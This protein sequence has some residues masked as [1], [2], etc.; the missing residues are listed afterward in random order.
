MNDLVR[1]CKKKLRGPEK[2]ARGRF[3]QSVSRNSHTTTAPR[4]NSH[5]D[6]RKTSYFMETIYDGENMCA[7]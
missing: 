5:L 6:A 3:L 2:M 4:A 7:V 1:V